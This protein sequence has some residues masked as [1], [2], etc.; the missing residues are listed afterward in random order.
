MN[1]YQKAFNLLTGKES[2]PCYECKTYH[3][4]DCEHFKESSRVLSELVEKATPKKPKLIKDSFEDYEKCSICG[5]IVNYGANHCEHCG[6][7]LDWSK[8]NERL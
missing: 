8:E 2:S 3:C 6:Q 5:M 1:K 4:E 7:A